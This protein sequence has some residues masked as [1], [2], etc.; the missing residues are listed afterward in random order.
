MSHPLRPLSAALFIGLFAACAPPDADDLPLESRVFAAGNDDSHSQGTQLHG[1]PQTAFSYG[2]AS[3]V[4]QGER[5]AATLRLDKGELLAKTA[6]QVSGTTPS[7]EACPTAQTG[8]TRGCGFK[9]EGQ[10]VCTSGTEV[11]LHGGA[12]AGMGGSCVGNPVMRVC[13]GEKPCEYLGVGYLTTGE[14]ACNASCPV[15]TFTC[16][17]SGVYTVLAGPRTTSP[18]TPGRVWL[19]T[20]KPT[21]GT[22][23]ATDKELRGTQLLGARLGIPAATHITTVEV[24]GLNNARNVT[25]AESPGT[26]DASGDTFLYRL[27][28]LS[29]DVPTVDL[30]TQGADPATGWAWAVPVRGLYS[31]TGARAESTTHFTLA[32]DP[33]VI[34]KCYRWGYKPWLD[35]S[36]AGPVTRAHWACTRMARADYCG[37]GTSFTQDGT[38]IRP[39]D[40]LTPNLIPA[41][42]EGSTSAAMPFEAGWNVWGP[43]CLSHWRW[44]HLTAG[45]V[46]LNAPVEDSSGHVINDCRDPDNVYGPDKCSQ[47]CD[48]AEEAE[49]FYG[50][51]LFNN[52]ESNE[53]AQSLHP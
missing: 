52:S 27:K 5:R 2:G 36:A 29:G 31:A 33:G 17:R 46:D 41:P 38:R 39:W 7:L 13:S 18:V 42:T 9:V 19:L 3:V 43:S 28:Y 47:I 23:P 24:V 16:P 1:T 44:K 51:I 12:C 20:L 6:L 4:F 10:G 45:C 22:F 50:S 37:N 25:I 14:S 40:D 53:Q 21:T 32:C 30:C 26:W 15:A 49:R 34:A 35:G 8:A 48:S 11:T